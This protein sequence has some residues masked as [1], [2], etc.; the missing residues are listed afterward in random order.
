MKLLSPGVRVIINERSDFDPDQAVEDFLAA[1]QRHLDDVEEL[2]STTV[3]GPPEDLFVFGGDL[4]LVLG[5][6]DIDLMLGGESF[7]LML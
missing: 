6:G 7:D 2:V 4:E 1:Q 5:I 3:Y